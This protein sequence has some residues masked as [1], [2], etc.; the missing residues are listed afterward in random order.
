LDRLVFLGH[1]EK[2][3]LG[4]PPLSSQR[5]QPTDVEL[6]GFAEQ[7]ISS[8]DTP[9]CQSPGDGIEAIRDGRLTS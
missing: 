2:I 8:I 4:I 7:D 3:A 1:Q 9:L 5:E 6:F